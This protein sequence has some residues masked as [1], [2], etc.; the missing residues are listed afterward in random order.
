MEAINTMTAISNSFPVRKLEEVSKVELE[1]GQFLVRKIEK[2][3][4]K[5]SKGVIIP[6]TNAE[7]LITALDNDTILEAAVAWW[8][9]Q[10]GE[11][12]K[13]AI[14]AG[15]NVI[16]P[17]DYS[18]E[19]IIAHLQE[20]EVKEGRVSKEKIGVWFENSL[21]AKLCYALK[22]KYGESISNEKV[23]E[24]KEIYKAGFQMLAKRDLDIAEDKKANLLK[25]LDQAPECGMKSYCKGK[26]V[27]AKQKTV[28]M[29]G[30]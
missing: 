12:C 7:E 16:V 2:G 30:L 25:L 24:M 29:L 17:S 19:S 4:G 23:L 26:L 5:E 8:Q 22:E 9:E 13:K 3:T 14:A 1:A 10:I 20:E 15:A 6:A 27:E 28:E 18:M 21:A 11:V